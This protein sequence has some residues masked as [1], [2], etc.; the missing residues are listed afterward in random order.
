MRAIS[1]VDHVVSKYARPAGRQ[2][3]CGPR[4]IWQPLGDCLTKGGC[5]VVM[6][7]ASSPR[8]APDKT[9]ARPD[10]VNLERELDDVGRKSAAAMGKALHDLRIPVGEVL[11]SPTYRARETIRLAR[12]ANS[13][14]YDELGDGGQSMQ[15]AV[16]E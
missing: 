2:C 4:R 5:V 7:H 8:E 14:P 11:T 6:R 13:K 16:P 12:W 3:E 10:N 15:Q 9:A 1:S